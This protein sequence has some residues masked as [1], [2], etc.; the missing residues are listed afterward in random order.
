MSSGGSPL[1]RRLGVFDA[2]MIVMGGVVGSGIFINPYV[3]A[4]LAQDPVRIL[5][6]WIL[7]GV[8]AL[9][10]GFLYAELA[11][12]RPQLNGQYAY[13]RDAYHPAVAFLYGWVLLLVIQTGGM[14]AV[15]ITFARYFLNF[16]GIAWSDA[17]VASATLAVLTIVNCFGV[18]SG[19]NVQSALMVLKI[20]AIGALVVCGAVLGDSRGAVAMAGAAGGFSL[21]EFGAAMTPVLFAYS[22][23]QTASFVAAEMQDPKRDLRR[24]MI[25]GVIGVVTLYVSINCVYLWILGSGG[26]AATKT[27]ASEVMERILGSA[28]SRFTA[29]AITISTLGFLSQGMLTAPRVYF[30]MAEDR[31]FFSQVARVSER[32]QAP[33]A[34]I[35]LQGVF[36]SIIAFVGGYEKILSYVVSVDF[37]FIG[38]TGASVLIFRRK[39]GV[40]RNPLAALFFVAVSWWVVASTILHDPAS[41]GIG[42][43][44]LAAGLPAYQYW[45]KTSKKLPD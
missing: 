42:L 8:I 38:L 31:L 19:A 12:R 15:A 44:I 24:A 2:T 33:V 7:G 11:E 3:V 10:G 9:A 26:L 30:S 28:G 20:L 14:A 6:A 13:L 5:G 1:A 23:W 16:T 45:R 25:L 34:A 37:F 4:Q 18:K 22:G 29:V 21:S 40:A 39:D 27:P 36:A 17:V 41:S 35:V 43:A 32:T